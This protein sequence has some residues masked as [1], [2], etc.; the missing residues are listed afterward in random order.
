MLGNGEMI[1]GDVVSGGILLGGIIKNEIPTW[2]IFHDDTINSLR[3]IAQI[4]ELSPTKVHVG[5][6]GPLSIPLIKKFI[7]QQASKAS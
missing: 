1:A 4:I 6:G 5:H 2:P 3:S 7:D